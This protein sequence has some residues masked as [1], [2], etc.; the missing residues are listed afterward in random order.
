[1]DPHRRL[2]DELGPQGR[3]EHDETGDEDHEHGRSIPGIG[4]FQIEAA[5]LAARRDREHAGE[6]VALAT[7]RTTAEEAA[8]PG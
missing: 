6:K 7:A 5:G 3:A 1:M 2:V 8:R 4:E